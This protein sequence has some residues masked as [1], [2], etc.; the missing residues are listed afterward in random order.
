MDYALPSGVVNTDSVYFYAGVSLTFGP[1]VKEPSDQVLVIVDYSQIT[2]SYVATGFQFSLDVTSN[3][4]LVVS[5]PQFNPQGNL[6]TF[7][8]TGGIAGQQYKLTIETLI[9]TVSRD[10]VLTIN[11]PS[12]AGNCLTV[13]PVPQ[14][15]TQIP[16]GEPTQGYINTGVRYF[17]GVAPPSNPNVLDQ[18]YDAANNGVY[19]WVTDGTTFEWVLIYTSEYVIDAPHDHVLYGRQDNLWEPIP[20]SEILFDAPADGAYYARQNHIW[21]AVPRIPQASDVPPLMDASTPLPG[22]SPDFARVDHVHPTDASLYPNTNPANYQSAGDVAAT[23]SSYMPLAG[24]TFGGSVGFNASAL[25]PTPAHLQIGGGNAGYVLSTNGASGI[26]WVPPTVGISDSPVNAQTYARSGGAWVNITSATGIPEAPNDGQLW[27][28][29]SLTWV[30]IPIGGGAGI[31]DAPND[32][33]K[34]ARQNNSWQ[35]ITHTDITDWATTLAPYALSSNIPVGSVATPLMNGAPSPGSSLAWARGDHVHPVDTSR[36]SASNPANYIPEAPNNGGGYV[37]RNLGWSFITHNDVSDWAVSI[38][39]VTVSGTAPGPGVTGP[40]P[41][42]AG[43]LWWNTGNQQ[44]YIWS[45]TAWTLTISPYIIPEPPNDGTSYARRM[46]SGVGSWAQLTHNDITDWGASV[47]GYLPLTGGTLTGGLTAPSLVSTGSANVGGTLSVL[48][49][50]GGAGSYIGFFDGSST[51]KGYIGQFTSGMVW[52]HDP[53]GININ[54]NPN[55]NITLNGPTVA[56]GIS[57]SGVIHSNSDITAGGNMSCGTMF[58]QLSTGG[59]V[60]AGYLHSTGSSQIDSN[61]QVNGNFNCSNTVSGYTGNFSY[62]TIYGNLQ[63]NQSI[64]ANGNVVAGYLQSNGTAYVASTLSCNAT[65]NAAGDVNASGNSFAHGAFYCDNANG[66]FTHRDSGG[67]MGMQIYCNTGNNIAAWVNNRT[68]YS[69]QQL[70]NGTFQCNSAG[71]IAIKTGG[72]SWAASSDKRIK[73]VLGGYKAGLNEVL[74]LEPVEFIYK[75]N[76]TYTKDGESMNAE[77]ARNKTKMVGYV[78]DDIMQVLP[79]TVALHNGFID[80]EEVDDL[81]VL[82][83]TNIIHALVNAVKELHVEVQS[84]RAELQTLRPA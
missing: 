54:L 71:G 31:S 58:S 53:T 48:G 69:L 45:G 65:I 2:P 21:A 83:Q 63:V 47:A 68:G 75:G 61:E 60:A 35:H 39:P 40:A 34:Y 8:L 25:F 16:V 73:D 28:R 50:G 41:N 22:S 51:R 59:T 72:G 37:R 42:L 79:E 52:A 67:N 26:S 81:K 12:S 4:A 74:Q 44:L 55:G 27:G 46:T 20:I 11:I 64:T 33:T 9:D 49:A 43:Q 66:G 56:Q 14:I 13:N 80:G 78:A 82:D 76:D 1:L 24:G 18:W 62:S 5:Y 17:W 19:E 7:L 29:E 36:Y 10:D 70:A 38:V 77:A 3:P 32:A 6:L 57:A 84:L 30:Q 23:L 15:Y